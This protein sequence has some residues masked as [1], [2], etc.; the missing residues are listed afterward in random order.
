MGSA[1]S[2]RDW[3]KRAA[4]AAGQAGVARVSSAAGQDSPATREALLQSLLDR[5]HRMHPEYGG[6]LANH[7]SMGLLS[8]AALGGTPAQLS[9]FA[10]S[11]WGSLD[12]LGSAPGPAVT[13]RNWT[14]LL[15]NRDAL[16]GFLALFR[17]EIA[18]RGRE[19]TLRRYLPRLLPGLSA[20]AFHS[21]IRTG[22]GVRFH[23]DD[24]V[25]DGLAYWAIA[26]LPLGQLPP[27]GRETE[28]LEVLRMIHQSP[29]LSGQGLSGELIFGKMK[30]A[31]ALPDFPAA[32]GA[33]RPDARTLDR[34]AAAA[35]RLYVATGNFTALHAVTGTHA[36]RQILPFVE[37]PAQ[38]VRYLWQAIAAAYI[39]IKAPAIIPP[40]DRNVPPW[41]TIAK[42][43]ASSRDAHDLKLVEIAIDEE[44]F[45]RDAIYR[46]AAARRM[47]LA[48]P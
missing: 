4:L 16:P 15:G 32:A 8:L 34:I 2:R 11:E 44:A 31:A 1:S 41:E 42:K 14:E 46:Q 22:Y 13:A 24:E 37:E 25:M 38:G 36:Y 21:L 6:G 28:P 40:T 10:D 26:C 9:G 20:G 5:N 43:A 30:T 18:E 27:A 48:G 19:G 45:Y 17:R 29:K 23:N 47:H 12:L 7:C 3:L 39:T 35:I 33:L